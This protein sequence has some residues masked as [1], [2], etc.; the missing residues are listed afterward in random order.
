M[1]VNDIGT[2]IDGVGRD[3]SPASAVVHEIIRAGGTAAADHGDVSSFAGAAAIVDATFDAYGRLD[4][5]VNNAGIAADAPLDELSEELVLRL[6]AVHYVGTVGICHAAI[7]QLRRQGHGRIVNTVS[8]AAL[9]SRYPGG[10]AYGGAKAAVWAATLAMARQLDGTG[11][12]VNGLSPGAL[13]RMNESILAARPSTLDLDPDHVARVVAALVGDDAGHLNG[14][15]VHA[16]AGE[17][18]EY[19]ISRTDQAPAVT[20]LSD[21]VTRLG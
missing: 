4:I 10:I 19:Q 12:T 11:V 20:W 2:S 1:L 14:R 16:A 21:A 9:D 6:I 5:V 15:V 17:V 7:P 13:T 3:E 8:E 18:R